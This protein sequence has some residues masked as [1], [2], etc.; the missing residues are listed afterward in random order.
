[1]SDEPAHPDDATT[2]FT[3]CGGCGGSAYLWH[4]EREMK[5]PPTEH[6]VWVRDGYDGAPLFHCAKE[7]Q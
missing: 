2:D 3:K 6:C 4:G 1:M 7:N 5:A